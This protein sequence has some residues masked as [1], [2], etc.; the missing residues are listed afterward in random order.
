[1]AMGKPKGGPKLEEVERLQV[2]DHRFSEIIR[3]AQTVVETFNHQSDTKK[4]GVHSVSNRTF[5]ISIEGVAGGRVVECQLLYIPPQKVQLEAMDVLAWGFVQVPQ[6]IGFNIVLVGND[7]VN[8]HG[9]WRTL[10]VRHSPLVQN[11]RT[12]EPFAFTFNQLPKE[13]TLLGTT[14]IFDADVR[15]FSSEMLIPLIDQLF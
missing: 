13:I 1:M 12:P 3:A 14:H 11:P 8:P 7:S 6:S 5:A 9:R 2:V 10:H 4:L 15:D